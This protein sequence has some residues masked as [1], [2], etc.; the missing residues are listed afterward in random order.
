[1]ACLTIAVIVGSASFMVVSQRTRLREQ[2]QRDAL[3]AAM[4]GRFTEARELLN[5]AGRYGAD[6][7]WSLMVESQL[8]RFRGEVAY[9]LEKLE[10]AVELDDTNV[11]AKYMLAN[12]Y[13]ENGQA[14]A[15]LNMLDELNE[16]S[17]T[18]PEAVLFKG[19]AI[20]NMDFDEGMRLTQE[21]YDDEPGFDL[22]LLMLAEA[23]VGIAVDR[24]DVGE[25]ER[26]LKEL[27]LVS[28]RL[29]QNPKLSQVRM[30]ANLAA[31]HIYRRRGDVRKATEHL[32]LA[33][34]DAEALVQHPQFL[35][36][37]ILRMFYFDLR[38]DVDKV[39][40]VMKE[41]VSAGS[42]G[43]IISTYAGSLYRAGRFDEARTLLDQMLVTGDDPFLTQARAFLLMESP[44]DRKVAKGLCIS[45]L[46]NGDQ[47]P[48]TLECLLLLGD[49]DEVTTWAAR[50]LKEVGRSNY[51]TL[52]RTLFKYL[53]GDMLED[54]VDDQVENSERDRVE[55]NFVIGLRK[56]ALGYRRAGFERLQACA[57][58]PVFFWS[59]VMWAR[60]SS[61]G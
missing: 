10:T 18:R 48:Y 14:T 45:S 37:N 9:A 20:R 56:L 30:L 8:D 4:S 36:G 32:D 17:V 28:L 51:R 16:V 61:I 15:Y 27:E 54:A 19:V 11:T 55:A 41:A 58:S 5:Q 52:H 39:A 33:G 25:I 44:E 22:A 40:A 47:D 3:T 24:D 29:K 57:D 6:Q 53:S 38:G 26:A 31:Y 35:Y 60:T 12:M 13:H 42:R 1:M 21:V 59:D 43:F 46:E 49:E 34:P 7:S 50:Q 2:F 23:R